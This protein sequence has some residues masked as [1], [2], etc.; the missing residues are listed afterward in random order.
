MWAISIVPDCGLPR[1]WRRQN[2]AAVEAAR[3]AAWRDADAASAGAI[4]ARGATEGVEGS[5]GTATV[6]AAAPSDG[7]AVLAARAMAQ[8]AETRRNRKWRSE[9]LM[10]SD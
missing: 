5:S 6:A 3:G 7:A 4:R 10:A 9:A 1:P 8:A 2:P